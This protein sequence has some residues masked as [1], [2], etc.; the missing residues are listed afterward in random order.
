[1]DA[2]RCLQPPEVRALLAHL[3]PDHYTGYARH[4]AI[5]NLAIAQLMLEAGCRAHELTALLYTDAFWMGQLRTHLQ[6]R[7]EVAKYHHGGTI[8][9]SQPLAAALQALHA[10]YHAQ[11]TDTD[12]R[13]LVYIDDPARPMSRRQ[14]HRIIATAGAAAL[15]R[16]VF[17]HMLRHTFG[18]SL[19]QVADTPT[20]Q[21]LMRH[22]HLSSTEVY[23]H[24]TT[25]RQADAIAAAARLKQGETTP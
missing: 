20:L 17:P 13:Y 21:R 4:A 19:S 14:I 6:I 3:S 8:P 1:M 23:T 18:D 10:E 15:G 12:T 24:S 11:A 5:R 9:I 25:K 7:D 2:Y 16:P 22:L